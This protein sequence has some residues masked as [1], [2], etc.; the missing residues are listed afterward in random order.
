MRE[1]R[2]EMLGELSLGADGL[3]ALLQGRDTDESEAAARTIWETILLVRGAL[4][5]G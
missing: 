1:L 5:K 2:E 3:L 4:T